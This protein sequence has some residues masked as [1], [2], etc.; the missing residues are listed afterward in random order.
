MPIKAVLF[1]I[2]GTL[3]DSND[4]HVDVRSEVLRDA[5]CSI[6]RRAIHDQIGKGSDQSVPALLPETD[7]E[8]VRR[9]GE[10]HGE[11]FKARYDVPAE[12]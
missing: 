10:K 4:A 2:D 7:E 12:T 6:E 5:G 3:I 11:I 8:T 9:L 1:D